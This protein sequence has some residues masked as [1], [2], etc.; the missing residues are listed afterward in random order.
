MLNK[1]QIEQIRYQVK[2][3]GLTVSNEEIR[4]ACEGVDFD[5]VAIAQTI[6]AKQSSAI[7]KASPKAIDNPV[8]QPQNLA[9]VEAMSQ[10]QKLAVV[11][12]KNLELNLNLTDSELMEIVHSADNQIS[13]NLAFIDAVNL[14]IDEFLS[15]RNQK[16]ASEF[17]KRLGNVQSTIER[18]NNELEAI[19]KGAN[20]TVVEL[21]E[22]SKTDYKS[23]LSERVKSLRKTLSLPN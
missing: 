9:V 18:K 14:A 10:P 17:S 2:K 8:S 15:A 7:A 21:V 6:A 19:F 16:V 3:L 11:E 23:T 4:Q 1:N 12:Q 20:Q 22:G 5:P 13:D